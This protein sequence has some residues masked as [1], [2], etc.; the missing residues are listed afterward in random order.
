MCERKCTEMNVYRVEI[1]ERFERFKE[2][3]ETTEDD[4]RLRRPLKSR[5]GRIGELIRKNRRK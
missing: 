3:Y 2:E 5:N 1:I 4:S